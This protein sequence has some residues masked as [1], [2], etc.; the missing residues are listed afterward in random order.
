M[1]GPYYLRSSDGSNSDT[2]LTWALAKFDIGTASTGAAAVAAAGETI[3][4]SQSH[5][6]TNAG[7]VVITL[8]G[9]A[10]NPVKLLC[11][12][13]S[14]EPPTAM[15]TGGTIT[16]N[17]NI[18]LSG[19]GYV[20]G[21][22]FR[23]GSG[24]SVTQSFLSGASGANN[25]QTLENCSIELLTTGTG[26][27]KIAIGD[28]T[29]SDSNTYIYKST[30]FKVGGVNHRVKVSGNYFQYGGSFLS[31]SA[32]PVNIYESG[33]RGIGEWLVIG[34]DYSANIGSSFNLLIQNIGGHCFTAKFY[35]IK[36][37]TS[38]SGKPWSAKPL[39]QGIRAEIFD[40]LIGTTRLRAWV[41]EFAGESRDDIT[42]YRNGGFVD[43]VD[44]VNFS[45][46]MVSTANAAYPN[47]G[48]KGVPLRFSVA[49]SGSPITKYVEVVHDSQGTGSG[50][51]LTDADMTIEVIGPNGYA[52]NVKATFIATP[53]NH[54]TSSETW[55]GTGG[56]AAP[57]KQR[58]A[59]TFTPPRKGGY[60]FTPV[61]FAA[62]KTVYYCMKAT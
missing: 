6:E 5:A 36:F 8:A 13:D 40:S 38:W 21:M 27:A 60:T 33:L 35:G 61:L 45:I 31:G 1:A 43:D 9:T 48:H 37:P 3:W 18:T 11:G 47:V 17:S 22:R 54:A 28:E 52:T 2:G 14:A 25:T 32:S 55:T 44:S 19:S 4:C 12:D 34:A 50:S 51:A 20:A 41:E 26:L 49:T 24:G 58:L 57:V 39:S 15:A 56:M 7:A 29:R 16:S 59:I 42:I 62:S 23:P 53:A 10:Q 30:T 46:K